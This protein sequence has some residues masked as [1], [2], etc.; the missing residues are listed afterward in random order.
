MVSKNGIWILILFFLRS[1]A[2]AILSSKKKHL[3]RSHIYDIFSQYFVLKIRYLTAIQKGV[4]FS[5][6]EKKASWQARFFLFVKQMLKASVQRK[7]V[8]SILLMF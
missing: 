2:R 3:Q 6:G 5:S 4:I 1:I 8:I 7:L